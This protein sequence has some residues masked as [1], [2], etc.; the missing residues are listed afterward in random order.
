MHAL[1]EA[2][3]RQ[4]TLRYVR[5]DFSVLVDSQ[6]LCLAREDHFRTTQ[7]PA[8]QVLVSDVELARSRIISDQLSNAQNVLLA[9]TNLF[10]VLLFATDAHLD[11]I[12][13]T[14][15]NLHAHDGALAHWH[16]N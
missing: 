10:L 13:Q 4:V 12:S 7:D 11:T 1:L 8:Q 6:A 9:H 16:I 2:F 15:A 5:L 14:R 3:A